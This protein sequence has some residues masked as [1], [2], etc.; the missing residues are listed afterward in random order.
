MT[1]ES[2]KERAEKA[3]RT[4]QDQLKE[5][6]RKLTQE[7][8]ETWKNKL[9]YEHIINC[10]LYCAVQIVIKLDVVFTDKNVEH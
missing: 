1:L 10:C 5:L 4:H 9:T 6:R 8:E 3:A 7:L 2:M